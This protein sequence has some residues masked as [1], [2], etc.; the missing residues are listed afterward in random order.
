[1]ADDCVEDPGD[2]ILGTLRDPH[3]FSGPQECADGLIFVSAAGLSDHAS[4]DEA[5]SIKE[6][7]EVNDRVACL[8]DSPSEVGPSMASPCLNVSFFFERPVT[9]FH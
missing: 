9:G 7:V 5:A 4:S 2:E 1:M 8:L 3:L 6:A